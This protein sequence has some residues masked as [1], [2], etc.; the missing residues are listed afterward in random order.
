[1]RFGLHPGFRQIHE[2]VESIYNVAGEEAT[3]NVVMWSKVYDHRSGSW[4]FWDKTRDAAYEKL[5]G[6][7]YIVKVVLDGNA[8]KIFNQLC[9]IPGL[10]RY[11][12]PV[13][14]G[15][16]TYF[17]MNEAPGFRWLS[18]EDGKKLYKQCRHS[19]N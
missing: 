3:L 18:G 13:L 12:K 5:K 11:R 1:L 16:E 17:S 6:Q 14:E 9:A 10:G 8:K 7:S 19:A 15:Y 4:S 2:S